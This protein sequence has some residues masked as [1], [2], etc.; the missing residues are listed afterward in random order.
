M[1]EATFTA[2]N[3]DAIIAERERC[4]REAQRINAGVDQ[5]LGDLEAQAHL[6]MSCIATDEALAILE[7]YEV[8]LQLVVK[9]RS[10]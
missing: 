8:S 6:E 7:E 5:D 10:R 1:I 3:W 9:E 2:D 4:Y